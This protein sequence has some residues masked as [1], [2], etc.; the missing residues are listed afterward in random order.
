MQWERCIGLD[1]SEAKPALGLTILSICP[2]HGQ[3]IGLRW[4]A[5]QRAGHLKSQPFE[6]PTV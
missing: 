1:G 6:N 3:N 5:D 4:A 2:A